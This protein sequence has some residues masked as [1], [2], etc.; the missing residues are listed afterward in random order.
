M[1]LCE[2]A[3]DKAFL[4]ALIERRRLPDFSVHH[5]GTPRDP[6]GGNSK[7]CEALEYRY[8]VRAERSYKDIVIISDNDDDPETSSQNIKEQVGR[9]FD[10]NLKEWDEKNIITTE[11]GMPRILIIMMPWYGEMGSLETL[12][13]EAAFA[14]SPLMQKVVSQ[15]QF[16]AGVHK[17]DEAHRRD[18]MWLRSYLAVSCKQDPFVPMRDVFD[19][20][21][22]LN[23]VPLEHEC[24]DRL[25]KALH[26]LI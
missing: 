4:K 7:F 5:T 24:F 9:Y 25:A 1:I 20:R 11:L 17:W 15:F 3:D 10:L 6:T 12:C 14:A 21:S 18:E 8:E 19:R 22:K 23:L 26:Q 13:Y 2:G 16:E